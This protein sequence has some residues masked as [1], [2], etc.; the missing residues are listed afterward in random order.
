MSALLVACRRHQRSTPNGINNSQELGP[1]HGGESGGAFN[2]G[3]HRG[4]HATALHNI[5][6]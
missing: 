1:L 3:M 5:V 6:K 4:M 2:K